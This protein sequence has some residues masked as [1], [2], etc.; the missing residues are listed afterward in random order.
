[1]RNDPYITIT[2]DEASIKYNAFKALIS[3]TDNSC[4]I[5]VPGR[6]ECSHV[7]GESTVLLEV[8]KVSPINGA[9]TPVEGYDSK[10]IKFEINKYG[11]VEYLLDISGL[12]PNT[13]YNIGL[14]A[15]F[16]GSTVNEGNLITQELLQTKESKRMITTKSLAGFKGEW[17]SINPNE[18]SVIDTTVQFLETEQSAGSESA[19]TSI[20]AINKV[21]VRLYNGRNAGDLATRKHIAEKAYY[22]SKTFSI[23]EKFFDNAFSITSDGTFRL[24]KESLIELSGGDGLSEYYTLVIQAYTATNNEINFVNGSNIYSYYVPSYLRMEFTKPELEVNDVSNNA[25][26]K[27]FKNLANGGT[28]VGYDIEAGFSRA[29]LEAAGY[30]PKEINIYVYS[31]LPDPENPNKKKQLKFYIKND[32]GKLELVDKI[33]APLGDES[34][35]ATRIYMDYGTTYEMNDDIMTRGNDFY[36][37]YNIKCY[38]TINGGNDYLP[39]DEESIKTSPVGYGIYRK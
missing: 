37:G 5:G 38:D 34:H 14:R 24:D 35:Y 13:T 23:K 39:N 17:K 11:D 19:E 15:T 18:V 21:V 9:L 36:I 25:A 8:N 28:I 1:M 33:T 16:V 22:S 2:P 7:T 3:L 30:D 31:D 27:M 6:K 26:N 20:N 4:L 12:E 32:E 10:V 29:E